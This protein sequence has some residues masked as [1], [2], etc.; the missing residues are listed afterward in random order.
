[1]SQTKAQL[2]EPTGVFTLTNQLVGVG[3]T[4]SGNVS[5]G[6]TLTKQDVTNVDSV[7]IIT[8]RSGINI[9]GAYPLSL[10]T[11]TTIHAISNNTLVFGTNGTERL[12]IAADGKATLAVPTS[13]VGVTS[14]SLDIWGN[15]PQYPTLRLGSNDLGDVGEQIRFGRKDIG[16]DDIRYHSIWSKNAS[17]ASDNYIQFRLHDGSGSPFTGQSEV[18][19]LTGSGKVGIGTNFPDE[20][21]SLYGSAN[22]VRLRIDSQN[23]RRNNYIGVSGADNLEIAVDEDNAGGDS[24]LRIRIDAAEKVRV[25]ADGNIGVGEDDPEGN[26]ILIRAASTIGTTKG[27]IMLTGDSSTVGEG[28]QIVFSESGPGANW[29]GAYIGHSRQGGG[30]LGNLVFATRATGGDAN[31]IPTVALT[32]NSS[33]AAT[34]TSTVSD[35]KGNVR[36]VPLNTQASAYTL[37]ANDAGKA[38][39]ASG[40]VTFNNSVMSAGDVVTIINNTNGDISVVAGAGTALYNTADAATGTRTLASRGMAT[41]YFTHNTTG[42]ISGSGLS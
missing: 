6:G 11:G 4:F 8:A 33:Q 40:N 32:I 12:R 25:T 3:A 16:S 39:L 36:S 2:L 27:H 14:A 30:S 20:V 10:G 22:N 24:S 28:P 9:V 37:V 7:G 18:L 31:T 29:A 13:K 35:S 41:I 38:I 5:I 26:K 1:M 19:T 23:L 42:Y 17:N 34:F 15:G 21:L